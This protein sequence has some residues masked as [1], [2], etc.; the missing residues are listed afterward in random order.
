MPI[1]KYDDDDQSVQGEKKDET[2]YE[3]HRAEGDV[4]Y[5]RCEYAKAI[6]SYTQ[7]VDMIREYHEDKEQNKER[8]KNLT[9]KEQDALEL[10]MEKDQ[11]DILVSRS[12]C[13]LMLGH[14]QQAQEDS[15]ASL[16]QDKKFIKGLYQKAE[17]LYYQGDFEKALVLYHRGNKQRPEVQEFRLGIQKSQEA[18]NNSIGSPE[19]VKLENKGD[20][21]EF[22]GKQEE[23]N[24]KKTYGKPGQKDQGKKQEKQRPKTPK[25]SKTVKELLGQLYQDR[26]Y[27]DNLLKEEESMDSKT[28]SSQTIQDLCIEGI[29]YLDSRTEFWR[30]QKPMYARKRDRE[31]QQQQRNRGKGKGKKQVNYILERIEEIDDDQANGD[32]EKSLRKAKRTHKQIEDLDEDDCDNKTELLATIYSYMGNSYLELAKYDQ[33]LEYHQR[34]LKISKDN[35]LEDGKSRALDNLGRVYARTGDFK[36]ATEV[37]EEKLPL[38]QSA[39]ESTWLLHEIG[40]CY[41]ELGEYSKSRDYG[42]RSLEK[43]HDTDDDIWQL[44]ASVLIAQSEVKLGEL[45]AACDS[46]ERSLEM[47]RLQGD[48]PAE[49]AIKK[50]LE[51]VNRK[52]VEDARERGKDSDQDRSGSAHSAHSGS[53]KKALALELDDRDSPEEMHVMESPRESPRSQKETSPTPKDDA[54]LSSKEDTPRSTKEDTPRSKEDTPRSAKEDT[55]RSS[56]VETPE[57]SKHDTPRSNVDESP[58]SQKDEY[59]DDFEEKLDTDRSPP[60]TDRTPRTDDQGVGSDQS[61][62]SKSSERLSQSG[63]VEPVVEPEN[64]GSPK[65]SRHGSA[66]SKKSSH[67]KGQDRVDSRASDK[68]KKDE[69]EAKGADTEDKAE[70]EDT[71]AKNEDTVA[72]N[73]D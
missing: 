72:K 42:E 10:K 3:I 51:D 63:E 38:S 65:A 48:E 13:H 33:A 46:F 62:Q 52:I 1:A 71:V 26:A 2:S 27:L 69:E 61:E 20:L 32:Y 30:Q 6:R 59:E 47:A 18:I 23:K 28:L 16:Q 7:A 5:K 70:E 55:P 9:P 15:E 37:W 21:S 45:E 60:N 24:K 64:K 12:K 43:A 57:L 29:N 67:S 44:N 17:A 14:S 25:D 73:E 39:L 11:R 40:R 66:A 31:M 58:R 41:L 54:P 4:L 19:S 34:D 35:K 56:K 53:G 36:K 49:R 68:G 22:Y 50:A 8:T